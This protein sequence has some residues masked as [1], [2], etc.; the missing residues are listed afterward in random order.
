[1]TE[2]LHFHFSLSCIGEGN[3]NPLQ[4]SCLEDPRDRGA[5]WAAVCGVAQS[6]TRLKRLSSSREAQQLHDLLQFC[7]GS[8]SSTWAG[9]Q[10][11]SFSS[12][13]PARHTSSLERMWRHQKKAS[14]DPA[15]GS[16]IL[17]ETQEG[18][19]W[20]SQSLMQSHTRSEREA[21]VHEKSIDKGQDYMWALAG[22]EDGLRTRILSFLCLKT[23]RVFFQFLTSAADCWWQ[24][25]PVSNQCFL[26][27]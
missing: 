13:L 20:G 14:W 22:W 21:W 9:D 27:F 3:G 6:R 7:L 25:T 4:Y 16:Y 24:W 23:Q 10:R 1:M 2:Q 18:I 12:S 17:L 5:W 11:Q 15:I 19:F 8:I 26:S